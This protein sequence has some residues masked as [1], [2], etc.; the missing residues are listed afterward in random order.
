LKG[1]RRKVV[2]SRR[3]GKTRLSYLLHLQKGHQEE[4]KLIRFDLRP[5]G[6]KKKEKKATCPQERGEEKKK[7]RERLQHPPSR[8]KEGDRKEE[9]KSSHALVE[10]L[11][12]KNDSSEK[13]KKNESAGD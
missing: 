10:D 9:K 8:R 11:K 5:R 1:S 12:I 13:I 7:R 4:K 2:T 3:G 6:K